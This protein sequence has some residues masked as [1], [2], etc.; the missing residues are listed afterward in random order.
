M[1]CRASGVRVSLAHSLTHGIAS[2][3]I[4]LGVFLLPSS[5]AKLW[6]ASPFALAMILCIDAGDSPNAADDQEGWELGP[7]SKASDQ[8]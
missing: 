5:S 6:P 7:R 1:A 8:A 3:F 2:G 4:V